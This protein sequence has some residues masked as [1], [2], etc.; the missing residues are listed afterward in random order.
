[1]VPS[2]WVKSKLK[3]LIEIKHGFAFKSE[4]YSNS[5]KYVLLTP[6]HFNEIGGFRELRSK[7][8]YYVGEFPKRYV[9]KK[10]ALLLAMTEQAPGLLGSAL[11]VPENDIYLHNQ[12]LGLV[13]VINP[14]TTD[15]HFL[16]WLFNS[17]YVREHISKE[18]AGSKVRH[19]S[20]DRL[21]GI[22]VIVP[23]Y[24]EQTRIAQIL[25]TWDQAIEITEKLIEN[26]K[27][28]KKALM[29]QLLTGKRRLPGFADNW[30]E[31]L[32]GDLFRERRETHRLDLRLLSITQ[33]QGVIYRDNVGRKDTSSE[34]K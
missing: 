24:K 11:L 5:G 26:S 28:Q 4:W 32:L 25:S 16:F 7:T 14:D 13:S 2:G 10:D 27:A 3:E 19:T 22:T 33:D 21:R 8:K 17:T 31:Y 12:R 29:Q 23:P 18:A 20:P 15:K 34:D 9:L 6:G 1:M 30:N